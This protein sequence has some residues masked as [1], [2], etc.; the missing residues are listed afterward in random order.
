[1]NDSAPQVPFAHSNNSWHLLVANYRPGDQI[2]EFELL[3][4]GGSLFLRGYALIRG[5]CVV[6]FIVTAMS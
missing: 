1:Q 4:P 5:Q 2:R 6:S 3:G